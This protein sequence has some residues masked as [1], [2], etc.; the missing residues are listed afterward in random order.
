MSEEYSE[1]YREKYSKLMEDL[2]E[3]GALPIVLS[4]SHYRTSVQHS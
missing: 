1:E 4:E 2:Y 3:F